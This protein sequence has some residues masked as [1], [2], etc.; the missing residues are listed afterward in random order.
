VTIIALV[1]YAAGLPVLWYHKY[2]T[3][4][5]VFE[6][7]GLYHSRRLY[8]AFSATRLVLA[9]SSVVAIWVLLGP[10]LGLAAGVLYLLIGTIA[11]RFHY[12]RQV[13]K[14]LAVFTQQI[15]K[16]HSLAPDI[17]LPPE[18]A[19]D[20]LAFARAQVN[21]AMKGQSP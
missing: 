7:P 11:L 16:E 14:W 21:K 5:D 10:R 12:N 9:W 8:V 20:A 15:A 17:T 13:A 6:K 19:R 4:L 3:A 2:C 18:L 1:V